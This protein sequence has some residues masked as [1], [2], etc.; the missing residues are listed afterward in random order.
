MAAWAKAAEERANAAIAVLETR[1]E[2]AHKLV[3][4]IGNTGMTGGYQRVADAAHVTAKNW[5]R[6]AVGA[7]VGLI[8]FALY[9]FLHAVESEFKWGV[10]AARVFV[11]ITCGILATY[12]ATMEGHLRVHLGVTPC[13]SGQ[14]MRRSAWT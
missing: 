1:K 7:M 12:A 14:G 11:A 5:E 6:I 2:E 3:Q 10:F 4:V 13:A 9:A 8:A